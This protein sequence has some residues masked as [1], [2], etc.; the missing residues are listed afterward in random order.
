MDESVRTAV[1]IIGGLFVG[2][3]LY[4]ALSGGGGGGGYDPKFSG[5]TEMDPNEPYLAAH[6][7][8]CY[9]YEGNGYI[10][11]MM[12]NYGEVSIDLSDVDMDVY[13]GDDEQHSDTLSAEGLDLSAEGRDD[14]PAVLYYKEDTVQADAG[15]PGNRT[16]YR[17]ELDETVETGTSYQFE[18]TIT[19]EDD[20][21]VSHSCVPR[22]Y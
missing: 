17:I 11:V 15:P 6:N 22:G 7:L 10:N 9:N 20:L 16:Y 8:E 3:V 13:V 4:L 18:F 14:D 2:A 21:T 1:I 19:N 12:E 5:Y